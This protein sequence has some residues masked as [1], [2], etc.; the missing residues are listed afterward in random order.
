MRRNAT[1]EPLQLGLPLGQPFGPGHT[2]QHSPPGVAGTHRHIQIHGAWLRYRLS[3]RRRRTIG[4]MIDE[5]GLAVTAPHHVSIGEI[6]RVIAQKAGW[7]ASRLEAWRARPRL[8]AQWHDG[9]ELP[10]LGDTLRL[11]LDAGA[12]SVQRTDTKLL[13]LPLPA[14]ATAERL[15]DAACAWLQAEALEVFTAAVERFATRL[16]HR[17]RRIVLSSARTLWGSCTHDGV[18]RLHW[19]LVHFSPAI[20]DYVVAHEMAHL[21]VLDHST[22]FWQT[23]EDL[24]PGFAEPRAAL[25]QWHPASLDAV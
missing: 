18:I 11:H 5:G 9:G 8:V 22:R 14:T 12:H 15:R 6:E 17:P 2:G 3:R 19:R 10:F 24:L 16:G 7:I 13:V 4:L 23:L 20:I 25:K 21:K 1:A